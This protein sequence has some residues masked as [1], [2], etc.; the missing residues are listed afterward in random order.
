MSRYWYW[1]LPT[2]EQERELARLMQ[3][4]ATQL[5]VRYYPPHLTLGTARYLELPALAGVA[6][7]TDSLVG[8]SSR[9]PVIGQVWNR[10]FYLPID[11][12]MVALQELRQRL[13][14][15][16]PASPPHI[17]LAYTENFDMLKSVAH[18]LSLPDLPTQ[19][20]FDRIAI[21]RAGNWGEIWDIV[22]IHSLGRRCLHC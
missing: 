3:R 22:V 16:E 15:H 17:S 14:L 19:I 12:D 21:V 2:I 5:G 9:P 11:I 6:S 10:A 8:S 18:H 13:Q 4:L 7:T 1:L 20:S